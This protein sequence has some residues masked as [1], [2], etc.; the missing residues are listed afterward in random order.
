M[1]W[2]RVFKRY[3]LYS[4]VWLAGLWLLWLVTPVRPIVASEV[5][6]GQFVVGFVNHD[7]EFVTIGCGNSS[8]SGFP[9]DNHGPILIRDTETGAVKRSLFS[10]ADRFDDLSIEDNQDHVL[11][12]LRKLG[13][14]TDGTW[15]YLLEWIDTDSGKTIASFKPTL[16][17]SNIGHRSLLFT[18]ALSPD[19]RFAVYATFSGNTEKTMCVEISTGLQI[20][21]KFNYSS[22][23]IRFSPDG[24]Y[25]KCNRKA[26]IA[27]LEMPTGQEILEIHPSR[28]RESPQLSG[29]WSPDSKLLYTND[30][31]IWNVETKKCQAHLPDK[32]RTL[33][34]GGFT[35][36]SRELISTMADD[37]GVW[38]TYYDV[39]TGAETESKRRLVM[40]GI[41]KSYA[42]VSSHPSSRLILVHGSGEWH[43]ENW[44]G[45]IYAALDYLQGWFNGSTASSDPS[46]AYYVLVDEVSNKVIMRGRGESSIDSL[47]PDGKYLFVRVR[48]NSSDPWVEECWSIAPRKGIDAFLNG[49]A[50]WLLGCALLRSVFYSLSLR[51]RKRATA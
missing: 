41:A 15:K 19:G 23:N 47:S 2:L 39:D 24:R 11:R 21:A 22:G 7:R 25:L 26:G 37:E 40:A 33:R 32:P 10:P 51:R 3:W 36:D 5:Y 16:G 18:P 17:W 6:P 27:V 13:I 9:Y 31:A 8:G 43:K 49:G 30:G 29:W 28:E 45:R 34:M 42:N 48:K 50:F 14:T 38:L 12:C 4:L 46:I 20:F 44:M 35:A 1:R